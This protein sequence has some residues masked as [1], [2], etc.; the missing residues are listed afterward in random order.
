[1]PVPTSLVVDPHHF[2]ADLDPGRS[3]HLNTGLDL[4]FFFNVDPDPDPDSHHD[5]NLKPLVYRPSTTLFCASKAFEFRL[6]N[7][8][9]DPPF[10]TQIWIGIQLF[11]LMRIRIQLPKIIL[12]H[13]SCI[14]SALEDILR[15]KGILL[16]N[17]W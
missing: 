7:A 13:A 11:T 9:P 16:Y 6:Q 12:I 1:M 15:K 17:Q 4:T 10:F 5:T 3:V 2:S 8:D 14:Q